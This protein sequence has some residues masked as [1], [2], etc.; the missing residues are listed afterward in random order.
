MSRERLAAAEAAARWYGDR[1]GVEVAPSEIVK[2]DLH[3]GMCGAEI[4]GGVCLRQPQHAGDHLS[5]LHNDLSG[6]SWRL[7]SSFQRFTG[8]S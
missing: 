3:I 6:R 8:S 2:N 4:Q 5:F 7:T 1:M